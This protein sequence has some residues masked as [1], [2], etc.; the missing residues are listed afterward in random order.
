MSKD[1]DRRPDPP[2]VPPDIERHGCT[3]T[4]CASAAIAVTVDPARRAVLSRRVR[5][6]VMATI[7]YNIIEGVI[8]IAAGTVASSTAL[9]GFGLDSVIDV[10]SAAA[11]AWQ[12]FGEDPKSASEPR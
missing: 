12:F 4:C 5:L 3:D 11:V 7:T 8:A 6:L 10:A 1:T 9:I 2:L